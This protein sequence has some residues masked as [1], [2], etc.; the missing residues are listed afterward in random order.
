MLALMDGLRGRGVSSSLVTSVGSYAAREARRLGFAA[1]ELDFFR[2]RLDP[3]LWFALP[4][5]IRRLNPDLVHAHGARACLPLALSAARWPLV[6]TVHGYHFAHKPRLQRKAAQ[7]VERFCHARATANVFVCCNDLNFARSKHLI[8]A[9][10]LSRVIYNGMDASID[11]MLEV[12][13]PNRVGFVGRLVPQKAPDR[14]IQILKILPQGTCLTMI[15]GGELEHSLREL[16]RSEGAESSV[17][18]TGE[19]SREE[20]LREMRRCSVIVLPSRWEGLPMVIA[21]ALAMKRP[22]VA[23]QVNGVSEIVMH[24][25]NGFLCDAGD[26]ASF[27]AAIQTL[28]TDENLL[29]RFGD[30]GKEFVARTFSPNQML[31][32]HM[33]LYVLASVG[34]SHNIANR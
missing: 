2:S 13:Q 15:G 19:L 33:E 9:T 25:Q 24:G 17:T 28:L 27:A 12:R 10:S 31:D 11:P 29:H 34:G 20:T 8:G 6:Y 21:E 5:L 18:I 26:N 1:F 7:L 14:M 4:G 32:R 22:V 3:F 16:V 30:A 23:S